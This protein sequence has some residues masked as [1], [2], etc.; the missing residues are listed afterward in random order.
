MRFPAKKTLSCIWNRGNWVEG[1]RGI[2]QYRNGE[3]REQWDKGTGEQGNKGTREQGNGGTG[4]QGDRGTGEQGKR[5][6]LWYGR[7]VM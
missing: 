2:E 5:V 6:C 3:T 7:K 4:E 1:N